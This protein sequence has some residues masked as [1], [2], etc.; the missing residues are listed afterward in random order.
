MVDV[1]SLSS[2]QPPGDQWGPKSM[3]LKVPLLSHLVGA[4][5]GKCLTEVACANGEEKIRSRCVSLICGGAA[6][7]NE[8]MIPRRRAP[9]LPPLVRVP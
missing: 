9:Y 1:E 5:G 6:A 7:A 8:V 3:S 4:V 2:T